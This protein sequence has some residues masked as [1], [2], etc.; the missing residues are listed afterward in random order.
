M[1]P[2]KFPPFASP[3]IPVGTVGR[4]AA[5]RTGIPQGAM[6]YAGA[7]DFICALLGTAATK[8]GRACDR[9]GS[10]EG[11]NLCSKEGTE[12]PRLIDMPHV[13]EPYRNVS[14]VVS[15]SGKAVDWFLEAGGREGAYEEFFTEIGNANAGADGLIFL[16]YLAG[17]RA[18]IWDP[19][20]KGAFLGLSLSHGRKELG[21]ALV[22]GTVFAIRDIVEVMDSV[23]TPVSE[24]RVAG[25][26]GKNSILNRI[27]ADILGIP[28][29]S[30]EDPE[31]ELLGGACISLAAL[32]EFSGIAEAAENLVRFEARFEP[33]PAL[34]PL[35]FELFNVYKRGYGSLKSI[36]HDIDSIRG[37]S[38]REG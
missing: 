25:A 38:T 20:A 27:K 29:L 3:G 26:Q 6:V 31:A 4:A 30:P 23:G 11:I 9:A 15:T 8:P 19:K 32:G 1:D 13:V 2:G 36:F 16:P 14:G 24:L 7:P 10:S 35:Y 28:V 18:P 17:E 5:E 37:S 33:N 12:D 21:R 22:E 34:C